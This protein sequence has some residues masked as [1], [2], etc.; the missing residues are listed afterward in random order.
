[1]HRYTS[2]LLLLCTLFSLIAKGQEFSTAPVNEDTSFAKFS[3]VYISQ[4]NNKSE[5]ISGRLDKESAKAL[6]RFQKIEQRI[7][8]K[9]ADKDSIA[10]ASIFGDADR[11]YDEL[12][13]SQPASTPLE[14]IPSLD[15]IGSSLKFLEQNPK[16]AGP[17]A[18]VK[19]KLQA[20]LGN[21]K[22]LQDNLKQAEAVR[23]FIKQR[24]EYLQQQLG[25]LNLA[26]QFKQLNKQVYYYNEQLN[27]YK[28]LLKDKK[29]AE[30]K[31]LSLLAKTKLFKDFMRKNSQLASLFRL[32][33]EPLSPGSLAGLQSRAQVTNLIQ[34]QVAS[35]GPTA[36]AQVQQNI[37]QGQAQLQQLKDKLIKAGKGSSDDIMPEGFKP[38]GQKKKSFLQRLELGMNIQSQR[39]RGFLP[40]TSDVGA[41]LG[42]K[43]NDRSVFG[44]GAGYRMGWG[45]N[46]RHIKISNEGL[47]LR[48]FI[49]W[50]IKGSFWISG[51][52]EANYNSSFRKFD[53]LKNVSSWQQSGLIG[54]SKVISMKMKFFK[55]TKAQLLWDM[56]S[57]RQRPRTQ[58]VIFRIGYSF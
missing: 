42:Y 34:Q 32:P 3:L 18:E 36:Q 21:V 49:D 37:Q 5:K 22:G 35:G 8:R 55:S 7:K 45:P 10:A 52:Y 30:R 54:L 13:H 2:A 25:S 9:A 12:Q 33:D 56:L 39:A 14:Y 26:K 1:M 24:K 46:I 51:G 50:K 44:I 17:G 47:G 23:Q 27:E 6:S 57:Y 43:L 38:N 29:K 19:D 31:A 20:A 16:L 41:S 53:E 11:L 48:S 28:S 15:S 58:P 4:V 40:V